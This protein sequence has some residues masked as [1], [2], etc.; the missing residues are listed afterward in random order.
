MLHPRLALREIV[1]HQISPYLTFE[2]FTHST[3]CL[4]HGK[5]FWSWKGSSPDIN[6]IFP[7]SERFHYF[8][9]K[10]VRRVCL[11]SSLSLCIFDTVSLWS[12]YI[13]HIALARHIQMSDLFCNYF[14]G[15]IWHLYHK[16]R[17]ICD[18][19]DPTEHWSWFRLLTFAFVTP[20]AFS[21]CPSKVHL[22][23][24]FTKRNCSHIMLQPK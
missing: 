6:F 16:V 10:H 4:S 13:R 20:L 18:H 1:R 19:C 3:A 24:C 11:L 14:H 23:G 5:R 7:L 8:S 22:F 9:A 12:S 15:R 21:Q 2:G 17:E